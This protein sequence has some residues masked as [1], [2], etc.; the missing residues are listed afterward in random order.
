M[1]CLP[2]FRGE[3]KRPCIIY[4]G[5]LTPEREQKSKGEW[6]GVRSSS[7][8]TDSRLGKNAIRQRNST[9]VPLT[10]PSRKKLL[11]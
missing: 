5:D 7:M 1:K 6:E 4:C 8:E 2:D 3:R 10:L 9:R 11:I